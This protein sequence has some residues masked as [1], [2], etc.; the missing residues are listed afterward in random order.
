MEAE[1]AKVAMAAINASEAEV[2]QQSDADT[3]KPTWMLVRD[4]LAKSK[5]PLSVPQIHSILLATE[6]NVPAQDA[7]RVAMLRKPDIFIKRFRLY[8]L[9]PSQFLAGPGLPDAKPQAEEDET[10]IDET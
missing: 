10:L 2:E 1:A 6:K 9:T 7:I 3:T 4:V 5:G 8:A